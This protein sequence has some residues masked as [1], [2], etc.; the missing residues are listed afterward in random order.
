MSF[1][2]TGGST[3]VPVVPLFRHTERGGVPLLRR[4]AIP[5]FGQAVSPLF[6]LVVVPLFPRAVVPSLQQEILFSTWV[7]ERGTLRT[8]VQIRGNRYFLSVCF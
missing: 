7:P 2:P 3:F 4:V 6:R 8:S 1:V 5:M